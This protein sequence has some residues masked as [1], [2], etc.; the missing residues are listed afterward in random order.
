VSWAAELMF[1]K[2]KTNLFTWIFG[3]QQD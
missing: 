2:V 1:S 3:K